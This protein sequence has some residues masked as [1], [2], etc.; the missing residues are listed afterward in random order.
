MEGLLR[1]ALAEL[2]LA[3]RRHPDTIL[4]IPDRQTDADWD[5]VLGVRGC[6]SLRAMCRPTRPTIFTKIAGSQIGLIGVKSPILDS[7]RDF[8]QVTVL[9]FFFTR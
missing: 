3:H 8:L 5:D 2:W 1:R 6:R 9:P 4:P 7:M